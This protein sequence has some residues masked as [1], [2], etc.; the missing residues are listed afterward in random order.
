M[1]TD[2]GRT[3]L[4]VAF[5]SLYASDPQFAAAG[6]DE[7]VSAAVERPGLRLSQLVQTVMDGYANQSALGQRAVQLVKDPTP[8]AP[9]LSCCRDSRRSPT[10]RCGSVRRD[11]QRMGNKPV[12]PGD[13]VCVLGFASVDYTILDMALI[14]LG[15]VSVP[16]QTSAA[17]TQLVP[18]VTETEPAIIAAIIDYLPTPSNSC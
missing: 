5:R 3:R 6:P 12:R 18:I 8:A 14:P 13:R 10:G 16:L 1:S 17:L 9:Q 2:T 4:L 11:R 7:A 15:A